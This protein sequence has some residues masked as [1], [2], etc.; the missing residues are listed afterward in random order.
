MRALMFCMVDKNN[1][2]QNSVKS[3]KNVLAAG[4]DNGLAKNLFGR[5]KGM[6]K[7]LANGLENGLA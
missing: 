4:L 5:A 1:T 6:D 2:R 3:S 7:G